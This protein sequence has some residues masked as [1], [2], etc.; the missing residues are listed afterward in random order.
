MENNELEV[1]ELEVKELE[2]K[3]E[4]KEL[5]AVKDIE[6][7]APIRFFHWVAEYIDGT[8]L[9][10]LEDNGKENSF[11]DIDKDKLTKYYLKGQ[12]NVGFDLF[13]GNFFL[14]REESPA[15]KVELKIQLRDDFVTAPSSDII[16]YKDA[17]SLFCPGNGATEDFIERYNI[18]YKWVSGNGESDPTKSVKIIAHIDIEKNIVYLTVR[19]V[20]DKDYEGPLLING[21]GN[22]IVLR[23]GKAEEFI[24]KMQ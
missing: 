17:I 7:K 6:I 18:G 2:V 19:L 21:E 8:E 13:T 22:D 1:K 3:E 14:S 16:Q 24:I 23:K 15:F 11:Y 10:E 9:E 4:V 5:E 20:W 12:I